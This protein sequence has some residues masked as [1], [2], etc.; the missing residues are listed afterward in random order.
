MAIT[1]QQAESLFTTLQ[2]NLQKAGIAFSHTI[3][4]DTEGHPR[5]LLWAL[6]PKWSETT[7]G[8]NGL[9][10]LAK[11]DTLAI[12][13]MTFTP[14]GEKH[15]ILAHYSGSTHQLVAS[16]YG[17]KKNSPRRAQTLP[18]HTYRVVADT[19]KAWQKSLT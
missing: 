15:R 10:I 17:F 5:L 13:V 8:Q 11:G 3:D 12:A 1:L 14:E 7:S 19:L 2:S 6:A 4:T 16:L 18:M 9:A